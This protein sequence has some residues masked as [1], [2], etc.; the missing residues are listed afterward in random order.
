MTNVKDLRALGIVGIND[1]DELMK[2]TLDKREEIIEEDDSFINF[3]VPTWFDV[4]KAFGINV[5]TEENDSWINLYINYYKKSKEI[6]VWFTYDM[7]D[8]EFSVSVIMNKEQKEK[9]FA[10]FKEQ[11]KKEY[12]LEV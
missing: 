9:F 12:G 11:C 1:F 2:F 5:N 3:Y 7:P 4:D 8:D 6:A 10:R